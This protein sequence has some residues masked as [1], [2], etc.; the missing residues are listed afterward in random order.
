LQESEFERVGD[1]RTIAVDVRIVAATNRDLRAEVEAGRFREDLYYRLSVFPVTVPPLRERTEDI[2]P[3]AVHCVNR[4]CDELG[5]KRLAIGNRLARQLESRSWPGN[6][7]ELKN[8]M[9]RAVILSRGNRL[10]LD[11]G[12]PE[13]G[14]APKPSTPA[15]AEDGFLTESEFR[16]L[17]RNNLIAALNAAD[18]RVSGAGGAAELLRIKPST[19]S[20]R[21]KAFGIRPGKPAAS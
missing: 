11:P 3:L 8:V 15:I 16:E 5:R 1:D 20:Y 19:L 10:E 21:M 13:A 4:F 18:W 17:E 12:V 9:E 7:R 2:V 14:E 6:V